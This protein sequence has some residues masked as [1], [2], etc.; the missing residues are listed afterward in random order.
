MGINNIILFTKQEERSFLPKLA[1][2][3][4]SNS[5]K[6]LAFLSS[7]AIPIGWGFSYFFLWIYFMLD[8]GFFSD[9]NMRFKFGDCTTCDNI[10]GAWEDL[11]EFQIEEKDDPIKEINLDTLDES[12]TSLIQ[13]QFDSV[14][15]TR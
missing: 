5:R 6:N 10:N 9:S 11:N 7:I 1:P 12:R 8:K 2:S 14:S 3:I 13:F 4:V 15:S